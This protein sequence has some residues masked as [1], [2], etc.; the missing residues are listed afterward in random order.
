[1]NTVLIFAGGA[2]TRMRS[3]DTTPKQF[4]KLHGKDIIIHTIEHFEQHPEI[5]A[6][7]VVCIAS[8]ISYLKNLLTRYAITKVHWVVEGGNTGQDSIYN[9]LKLLGREYPDDT[10]VLI[11]DGVRPLINSRV[12]TDNIAC[13]KKYGSAI[14]VAPSVETVITV[15]ET[16]NIDRINDRSKSML[17]KAPQTFFLKDILKAHENA[18][19]E[20]RHDFI[21][22]ASI[23]SHYGF[24][25]KTV[26]GPY[27]NIKITT[28]S[29][30]YI[31]R[32]INEARENSQIFGI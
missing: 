29:D 30:Y 21:D 31:F 7:V 24:S 32:A 15:N 1:M 14:T 16:G 20:A 2:G 18:L 9:G 11:H 19:S 27:E 22:S 10:I 4:L 28:P 8:W 26:E 3:S 5:D 13:V 25:L 17:A 12:I 23:M 6:I